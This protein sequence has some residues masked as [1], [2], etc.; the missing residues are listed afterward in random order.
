MGFVLFKQL[1]LFMIISMAILCSSTALADQPMITTERPSYN[2]WEIVH[3][4]INE[5][6]NITA[7]VIDPWNSLTE[8]IL[9]PYGDSYLTEYSSQQGVVL[10]TYTIL[11][12]GE[13]I[14]ETC[15]FDIRT[16]SI[17]TSL[18]HQY[19]VGD[20]LLSGNITDAATQASVNASVNITIDNLTINTYALDGVFSTNYLANSTGPKIVSITAIDGENIT[21]SISTEFEIYAPVGEN[22]A[23]S[24]LQSL[25]TTTTPTMTADVEFSATNLIEIDPIEID[26][27]DIE[28]IPIYKTLYISPTNNNGT[29]TDPTNAYANDGNDSVFNGTW[30]IYSGYNFNIPDNAKILA[31]NVRIE[32][33]SSGGN[34]DSIKIQASCDG[35]N[36]WLTQTQSQV[37]TNTQTAYTVS[38]IG[39]TQW[40]SEKINNDSIQI[41]VEDIG[42]N[43]VNLDWIPILIT[44]T[45]EINSAPVLSSIGSQ[46]INE[47]ESLNVNLSATDP[48][49]DSIEY[50]TNATFGNL[51]DNM[52]TWTPG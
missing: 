23:P 27:I 52:F 17:N 9:T 6:S 35:G 51:T 3:I 14:S 20:I 19:P 18:E 44:Y 12:S 26:P 34:P 49:G 8:L 42:D 37:L 25:E 15:E 24:T 2:P 28:P 30:N 13:Q 41:K 29:C 48:D 40:T 47:S 39:W 36:T 31:V 21:S 38:A 50:S 33:M 5:T 32:A 7:H 45:L 16:L 4:S 46:T 43:T 1:A 11:V 22:L 10:G